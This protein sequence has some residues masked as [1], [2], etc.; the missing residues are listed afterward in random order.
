MFQVFVLKKAKSH[1]K[2]EEVEGT[3]FLLR[4]YLGTCLFIPQS[5]TKPLNDNSPLKSYP[6]PAALC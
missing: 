5:Y 2:G 3:L 6:H 4:T 1:V